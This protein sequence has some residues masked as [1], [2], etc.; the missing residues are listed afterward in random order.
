[1]PVSELSSQKGPFLVVYQSRIKAVRSIILSLVMLLVSVWMFLTPVHE[2][3]LFGRMAHVMVAY[4]GPP[5]LTLLLIWSVAQLF[6]KKP[7]LIFDDEGITTRGYGLIP[8][9][10][11]AAV[12]LNQTMNRRYFAIIPRD[13]EALA[14]QYP[15]GKAKNMRFNQE[16]LGMATGIGEASLPMKVE[17]LLANVGGYCDERIREKA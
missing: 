8:W 17:R 16:N 9:S 1:M 2:D 6:A 4:V 5:F 13:I 10:A 12:R 14:S 7:L 3:D 11:I 15:E